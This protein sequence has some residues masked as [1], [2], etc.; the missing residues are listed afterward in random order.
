MAENFANTYQTTLNDAGGIDSSVTSLVVTSA[1][2]APSANFRIKIDSELMLVTGVA[3]TTF[4]VTR[5]VE[6]TT[7]ASH[8]DGAAVTHVLTAGGLDTHL[9]ERFVGYFPGFADQSATNTQITTTATNGAGTT[10]HTKTFTGLA[11][12][13]YRLAGRSYQQG[14]A[15]GTVRIVAGS[16][17]VITAGT[18][19][20]SFYR[21]LEGIYVHAG[22]DL[23]VIIQHVSEGSS[24]TY[25][26]STDVRFGRS[27]TVIRVG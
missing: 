2:G 9:D 21:Y 1:T 25:G 19:N 20:V 11:A 23:T 14:N 24:V 8:A 4:T 6:S 13:T 22:G 26:I 16:T 10:L 17:E 3:G 12:G 15:S 18:H 27:L 7:A 5:G